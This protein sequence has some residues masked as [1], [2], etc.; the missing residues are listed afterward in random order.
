MLYLQKN[1]KNVKTLSPKVNKINKLNI[2]S[3]SPKKIFISTKL[4]DNK[5]CL[6]S[7]SQNQ[8]KIE[9][10][11]RIITIDEV[12]KM[13]SNSQNFAAPCQFVNSEKPN[14]DEKN[15]DN[16]GL[17]ILYDNKLFAIKTPI[18]KNNP[19]EIIHEIPL[20]NL[21]NVKIK[22]K[23]YAHIN[24]INCKNMKNTK[25]ILIAKLKYEFDSA[26][27]VNSIN[28]AKKDHS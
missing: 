9:N 2:K 20:N 6:N 3:L 21:K 27:F 8:N 19:I 15:K 28:N 22:S 25:E 17:L 10:I 18:Y 23:L 13:I 26:K 14:L 7:K 5:N 16:E 24:F 11:N 12:N 1:K 4:K